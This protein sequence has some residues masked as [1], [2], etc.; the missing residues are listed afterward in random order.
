MI[1]LEKKELEMIENAL[2]LLFRIRE[3]G[4]RED[5]LYTLEEVGEVSALLSKIARVRA[6]RGKE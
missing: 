4:L 2:S 6:E 1:E 5:N 3:E